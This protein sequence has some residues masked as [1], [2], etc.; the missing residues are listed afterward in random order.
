MQC[1]S[2]VYF[3][4]HCSSVESCRCV[5]S[6][7][8]LCQFFDRVEVCCFI[9]QWDLTVQVFRIFQKS[10]TWTGN[11]RFID[12]VTI[13]ENNVVDIEPSQWKI[14]LFIYPVLNIP[15]DRFLKFPVGYSLQLFLFII[16]V[17]FF[18][19]LSNFIYLI[20]LL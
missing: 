17:I 18:L 11:S 9:W 5:R 10:T 7:I 15:T 14:K 8:W 4:R 19:S 1:D 2:I 20:T 12:L 16:T 13:V 3:L 6:E